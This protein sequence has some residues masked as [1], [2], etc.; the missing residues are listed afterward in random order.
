MFTASANA[1][2]RQ[3][4]RKVM[5]S[6]D[7]HFTCV[8]DLFPTH[9]QPDLTQLTVQM[10]ITHISAKADATLISPAN[11]HRQCIVGIHHAQAF[12]FS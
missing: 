11:R 12:A 8:Q 1:M 6:G 2:R 3:R 7:F 5:L 10:I 9:T 4:I